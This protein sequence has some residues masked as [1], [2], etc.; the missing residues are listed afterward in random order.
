MKQKQFRSS[1]IKQLSKNI[2]SFIQKG[3][4]ILFNRITFQ[5][6]YLKNTSSAEIEKM[7]RKMEQKTP[8][9]RFFLPQTKKFRIE[10]TLN[11]NLNCEYCIVF[12]NNLAQL[13]HSMTK[14]TAREIIAFYKKNIHEGSLMITGGEPLLNWPV[15]K[16]FISKIKDPIKIFTNG[17]IIN[18]DIICTLK[19]NRNIRLMISLDGRRT[20][21]I[22]RKSSNGKEIYPLVI[23]NLKKFQQNNCNLGITCLCTNKNV[24]KLYE[25]VKFFTRE[26]KVK[27][28]GISFPH[29]ISKNL[30]NEIDLDIEKYTDSMIKIFDFALKNNIYIDQLAKRFSP[31]ITR[32]FRFYACKLV[33]E[34]K[35]FYPNGDQTLCTKIDSLKNHKKYN[36]KYFESKIPIN[37]KFCQKCPAIG[38]CGGG[39]FW[40]GIMRFR[41]GVDERECI[42]NNN[43][44]DYFLWKIYFAY[45]K[46]EDLNKKFRS[47]I[48]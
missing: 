34:Q 7:V 11:C 18:Q 44:L 31:L 6:E 48:L 32:R 8:E 13:N 2:F 22:M 30:N 21:N 45:K 38:I 28:L 12:K 33:G 10:I 1:Q 41:N 42:L 15:V 46:R 19:Q 20:E 40:D 16:L 43:L 37:N 24:D 14:N 47:L 39:C 25:I 27:F 3:K 9:T 36:L 29:Y 35:T 5:Q 23:K 17:T 26:P 4:T